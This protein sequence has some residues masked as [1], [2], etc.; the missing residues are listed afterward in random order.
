MY[1]NNHV[2]AALANGRKSACRSHHFQTGHKTSDIEAEQKAGKNKLDS[3]KKEILYG[4]GETFLSRLAGVFQV[5]LQAVDLNE[6]ANSS[7]AGNGKQ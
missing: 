3:R 6:P 7:D 2:A 1:M 5:G 4:E